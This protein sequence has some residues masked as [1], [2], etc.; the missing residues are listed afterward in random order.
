[1]CIDWLFIDFKS[2]NRWLAIVCSETF[3]QYQ[4]R[5][6][7]PINL[8]S[9]FFIMVGFDLIW[10]SRQVSVQRYHFLGSI[11]PSVQIQL[12]ILEQHELG[13][14]IIFWQI[15]MTNLMT[16]NSPGVTWF[17]FDLGRK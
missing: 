9:V 2:V 8:Y 15:L 10:P 12:G 4:A 6:R 14:L 5:E 16:S 3:E 7:A 11:L 13:T 17:R 1:M